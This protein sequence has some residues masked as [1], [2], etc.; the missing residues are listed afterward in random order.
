MDWLHALIMYLEIKTGDIWCKVRMNGQNVLGRSGSD[1]KLLKQGRIHRRQSR[2][3]DRK[4]GRVVDGL[5][6]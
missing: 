3:V 4:Q 1:L 5:M 2:A 6:D